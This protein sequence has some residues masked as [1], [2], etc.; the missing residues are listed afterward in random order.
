MT[1]NEWLFGL[2]DVCGCE[3]SRWFGDVVCR[4]CIKEE[5]EAAEYEWHLDDVRSTI[6][7]AAI[8]ASGLWRSMSSSD[9]DVEI[10]VDAR[11]VVE[12]DYLL[13]AQHYGEQFLHVNPSD[14]I[15]CLAT[16]GVQHDESTMGVTTFAKA[17][18]W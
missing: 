1:S 10:H 2:C 3:R 12:V 11:K 5:Q 17:A 8:T 6:R 9:A 16:V 18:G 4:N 15:F 7:Q 13:T 14:E